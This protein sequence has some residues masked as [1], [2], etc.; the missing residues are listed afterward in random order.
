M[1]KKKVSKMW[2]PSLTSLVVGDRCIKLERTAVCMRAYYGLVILQDA[3]SFHPHKLQLLLPLHY[4]ETET[5]TG[6]I[7]CP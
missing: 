1:L 4:G 6:Y 3:V 2:F 5:R 7:I